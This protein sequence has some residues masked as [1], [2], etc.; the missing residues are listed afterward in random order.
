MNAYIITLPDNEES[1]AAADRC[2]KSTNI[3][4]KSFTAVTPDIVDGL[5]ESEDIVWTYPWKDQIYD[6]KSGLKLNPYNTQNPKA[7]MACFMSHYMLWKKCIV[8]GPILILEHDSIFIKPIDLDSLIDNKYGI[9]SINDPRGATR[10]SAA[11]H[12]KVQEGKGDIVLAPII[13]D[14]TIPHG[15]PGNS[16]Y[17]LKPEH[18]SKL[19]ELV[20]EYGAWPNDALMCRQLIP[21]LGVS[22]T[23]YTKVQGLKSTTSL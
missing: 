8:E 23:Y 22:K 16:A 7:R 5:M 14:V 6:F 1:K 9:I 10:K 13:D 12:E 15:L 20:F 19:L 17:I 4:I 21:M 11:Y 3:E 2:K 18:A